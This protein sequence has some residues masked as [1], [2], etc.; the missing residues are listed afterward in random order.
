MPSPGPEA[1][2]LGERYVLAMAHE[3]RR[4]AAGERLGKGTGSSL[5]F[6]DRRA[7]QAGDD[8][9]HLDWRAF[10]RT[11]QLMVRQYREEILPRVEL[12][13]DASRSMAVE[14]EKA[15]RTVDLAAVLFAAGRAAG[16]QVDVI[17]LLDGPTRLE[18]DRLLREDLELRG[19]RPLA[20]E[21]DDAASLFRPGSLR[22]LLSDFLSP[23]DPLSLVRRL[24][25]RGGGLYLFQVLGRSD[26]APPA[27]VAL[28]LTDAEGGGEL[29]LVVD[30]R[31][32]A[33]YLER[34]GRLTSALETE[35]LRTGSLFL[36]LSAAQSLEEICRD[37]L[38][39][40]GVLV[41]A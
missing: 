17:A 27:D 10:A 23:H 11:D 2:A 29:D 3:P 4:G 24:A 19:G 34:L 15:R 1:F 5:E 22:I 31:T 6:Q 21:V 12:L 35:C 28:R 9:R 33:R 41:P 40:R 39:R 37:V 32:R 14:D 30:G 20:A 26:A 18:G 25:A 38:A 36:S 13:V 7:Y 16:F 8:I